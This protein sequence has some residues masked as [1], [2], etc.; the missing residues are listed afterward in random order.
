MVRYEPHLAEVME[1][2]NGE[3]GLIRAQ[4]GFTAG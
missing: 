4:N 1:L 2:L 3:K